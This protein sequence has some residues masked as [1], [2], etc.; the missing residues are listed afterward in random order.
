MGAGQHNLARLAEQSFERHGDRDALFFEGAWHRS[1]DLFERGRR[2]AGGLR[3]LGIKPGDRVVVMMSNTPDVGTLYTALW[4]AGAAITPAIFLLSDSELHNILV[5]S[6]AT[7]V[8][9]TPE[10]LSKVQGAAAG[11]ETLKWVICADDDSGAVVALASL[12]SAAPLEIVERADD[13]LA[14]LMY[15]GGT[16]G[17]A[18]GVML[19]H[20]NLWR[21]GWSSHEAGYVE[22]IRRSLVSLPLSHSFGLLVT[23]IGLHATEPGSSVLMKWFDPTSFL[24][25]AQEHRVQVVPVVPSM[26]QVLLAMPLESY[27]LSE[28]R[29]F[30]CGAAPL[31]AEVIHEL[32][33]RLPGVEIREGYGLTESAAIIS[34]NPPGRRRLG[35][36][37]LP[38]P[39][40]DVRIVD[41]EGAEVPVGE[42]G[43]ITARSG[44]IMQGYWKAP[45]LTAETVK[46]GWLRTGDIGHVDTDGYVYVTDRKKDLIIR[47]GFNV[48]PRD[49]EDVLLEHP[50]VSVAAV[51]GKPDAVSGEEV[52]AFVSL[53]PGMEVSG[54]DLVE[55]SRGRLGAYKYPREVRIVAAVPLTPVGKVDRKAVRQ[56]FAEEAAQAVNS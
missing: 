39:G 51:V 14:A 27:D 40:C 26:V 10:F 30:G 23:V 36:V 31:A 32:E 47:G 28:L 53:R 33:R 25:L 50:A 20:E 46:D 11:V 45:E 1:G 8:V 34:S 24:E 37:G 15:T 55:F 9:T 22:G 43:E 3:E 7:A 41:D 21:A 56:V 49:V 16:T 18:K 54:E 42:L 4:R 17:R 38:V 2:L 29:Y 19:S 6:E 48:Y 12:E 44:T 5:D 35:S 13:D 52:V